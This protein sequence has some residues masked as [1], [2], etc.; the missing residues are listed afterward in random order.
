MGVL[1]NQFGYTRLTTGMIV[2]AIISVSV[3]VYHVI[4]PGLSS[5][6]IPESAS[7]ILEKQDETISYDRL[8]VF[9]QSLPILENVSYSIYFTDESDKSYQLE[10][11]VY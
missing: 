8:Q 10:E 11:F 6:S 4:M 2:A 5:D 1:R 7:Q 3:F 9:P